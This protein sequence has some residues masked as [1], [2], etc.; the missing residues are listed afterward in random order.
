MFYLYNSLSLF[1]MATVNN[2]NVETVIKGTLS[3][4]IDINK[5]IKAKCKI[6]IKYGQ[7]MDRRKGFSKFCISGTTSIQKDLYLQAPYLQ[8]KQNLGQLLTINR[9]FLPAI[10][11]GI[12]KNE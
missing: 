12:S 9:W 8:K 2:E 6:C 1:N 7:N 5:A 10:R 3:E 11:E 4:E